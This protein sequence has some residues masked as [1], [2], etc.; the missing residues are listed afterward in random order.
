VAYNVYD[1]LDKAH[2]LVGRFLWAFNNI[3]SDLNEL[4]IV[5]FDLSSMA[6]LILLNS[7]DTRKKIDWATIGLQYQQDSGITKDD[8]KNLNDLHD[9]HCMRNIV[10]HSTYFPEPPDGIKFVH[11][12]ARSGKLRLS[13][14]NKDTAHTYASLDELFLK[15]RAISDGLSA[16]LPRC[17][18]VTDIE[19]ALKDVIAAEA[20]SSNVVPFRPNEPGT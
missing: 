18:A 3:E 2:R 17:T 15:A 9:L 11:T 14:T 10:A 20:K 16:I 13:S 1:E 5:L 12:T 4:L 7:V 19:S 6:S 8:R